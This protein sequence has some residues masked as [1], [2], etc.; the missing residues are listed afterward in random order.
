[1]LLYAIQA[2]VDGPIKLGKAQCP[3]E[4]LR[5]LQCG[6]HDGLRL[7]NYTPAISEREAHRQ[8]KGLRQRGEWFRCTPV[9]LGWIRE[10]THRTPHASNVLRRSRQP[11]QCLF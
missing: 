5:A 11:S 4:R 7:L 3:E 10:W 6:H 1:M 9:L 2:G 8:W